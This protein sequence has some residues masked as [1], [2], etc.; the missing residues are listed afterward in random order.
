MDAAAPARA[1]GLGGGGKGAWMGAKCLRV[2][3]LA[4]LK[5][6]VCAGG[7]GAGMQSMAHGAGRR[8]RHSVGIHITSAHMFASI[9]GQAQPGWGGLPDGVFRIGVPMCVSH[10]CAAL[11]MAGKCPAICRCDARR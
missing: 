4:T 3:W 11:A 5:T 7:T 9:L 1:Y 8:L 6:A 2:H 10:P